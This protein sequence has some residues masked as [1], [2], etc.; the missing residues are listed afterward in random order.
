MSN[1]KCIILHD[2]FRS[3]M[4]R[5]AVAAASLP[6]VSR[7]SLATVFTGI[8]TSKYHPTTPSLLPR[9]AKSPERPKPQSP[10]TP[11]GQTI[12]PSPPAP[13]TS[14]N[15]FDFYPRL[16]SSAILEGLRSHDYS[17]QPLL[18]LHP[19]S[20]SISI[21]M[22]DGSSP[23][24][25]DALRAYLT[26]RS[27]DRSHTFLIPPPAWKYLVAW[28]HQSSIGAA[29]DLV[30]RD[31]IDCLTCRRK[32]YQQAVSDIFD[33]T[34]LGSGQTCRQF[35]I[36]NKRTLDIFYALDTQ[37]EYTTTMVIRITE[38][39]LKDNHFTIHI[40]FLRASYPFLII[41]PAAGTD[42]SAPPI[43]LRARGLTALFRFVQKLVTPTTAHDGTSK[44][45]SAQSSSLALEIFSALS[46]SNAVPQA[47]T[48]VAYET[49]SR[50]IDHTSSPRADRETLRV[51]SLQVIVMACFKWGWHRR[52]LEL[53]KDVLDG[54]PYF[55][56]LNDKREG[57][58]TIRKAMS[59]PT[60]LSP[61][62]AVLVQELI[63]NILT[64]PSEK[65]FKLASALLLAHAD[66]IAAH[67]ITE[68]IP[69]SLIQAYYSASSRF[70]A[71]AATSIIARQ[72]RQV[73]QDPSS[74]L[75]PPAISERLLRSYIQEERTEDTK[76][77]V[78][79]ILQHDHEVNRD[80]NI[81]TS[82][83]ASMHPGFVASVAETGDLASSLELWLRA[84]E[85]WK[86][87]S[88]LRIC[89]NERV[90]S[91]IVQ[92][93]TL[94]KE[95]SPIQPWRPASDVIPGEE[96]HSGWGQITRLQFARSALSMFAE[97]RVVSS[98]DANADLAKIRVAKLHATLVGEVE[99]TLRQ[100][101][102]EPATP[103]SSHQQFDILPSARFAALLEAETALEVARRSGSLSDKSNTANTVLRA[104]TS[105]KDLA[106]P[107][108]LSRLAVAAALEG[109]SVKMAANIWRHS[110]PEKK[111]HRLGD[112]LRDD[113][114][115][116][117]RRGWKL[118]RLRQPEA[119]KTLKMMGT[120]LHHYDIRK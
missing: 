106:I 108:H 45:A 31:F 51:A 28:S 88:R 99:R 19:N 48:G 10:L 21:T 34:A 94:S 37:T 71:L 114:V 27:R 33:L 80:P 61:M 1:A 6:A 91:A 41:P 89:G 59:A 24:T 93:C 47:I 60:K 43:G 96:I 54:K 104:L 113:L 105:K 120:T 57:W 44:P 110:L 22:D 49:I 100:G 20:G 15:P 116:A 26:L 97:L 90:I 83:V 85:N 72:L 95:M 102:V 7:A 87:Y 42:S 2:I 29:T 63:L 53:L 115:A 23:I 67:P 25:V 69:S 117:V 3:L 11:F 119:R 52:A 112:S 12:F 40:P 64:L 111:S 92:L 68:P 62:L 55:A 65:N 118:G 109:D 9:S 36:S 38:A 16:S 58:S 8:P 76:A 14:P 70:P 39:M 73:L 74:Y 82:S 101:E 98:P 35:D 46:S 75:P 50:L 5:Y 32:S 86:G 107:T 77:L 84:K 81:P 66:S 30:I 79:D 103:L 56:A 13:P 4:R 78:V 18:E 17:S